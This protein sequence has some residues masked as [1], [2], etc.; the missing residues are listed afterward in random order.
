M[1]RGNVLLITLDQLS[2]SA[3][4]G[5]LA[6]YVPTPN[7]DRLGAEGT[8]F[9]NHFTVTVP[10][11]PARASLLTGLY[12]MNH[13]A[14]RNGTPL[15]RH[16][17][18]LATEARKAG[19]EPLL[20]GYTDFAADPT[21][22][23]PE[24]P[25][26][27]IY[28]GVAPGFREMVEMRL[29]GGLEWP[30]YLRAKGYVFDYDPGA[31]AFGQFRPQCDPNAASKPSDPAIYRA[32]DSDTAYLTDRTLDALDIRKTAPWFAHLTYLRPH[33]PLVAPAPYN[34]LVD[35]A[36]L[37]LP[38]T[39]APDHPFVEAWFSEASKAGMFWGFAGDCRG[40]DA[41]T[42]QACRAV[43]LGL[44]AEVDHHLG[45][46]L[47]WLEETGQADKTLVVLTADH[48]EMLGEKAMWGK[49][50]VFE[51]AYHVPMML[52]GPGIPVGEVTAL[53]ASVDVMPT[54][55]DWIGQEV[56]DAVDG[57]SL[58]PL[59][60]GEVSGARDAVLMEA[61]FGQPGAPTRFERVMGLEPLQTSVSILREARWK[62]IHFGGG[63]PPMLFDLEAD[64]FETRDVAPDHPDQV[65]RMARKMIDQMSERRDRRL[66]QISQGV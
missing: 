56:P 43:Y 47:D 18:T 59:A 49:D 25:D 45:R 44:L 22:R 12:A 53:T 57:R 15:A 27:S 10:C 40:M 51:P 54:V 46:V 21:G 19:Y 26:L 14:I 41:E 61:D 38:E 2:A 20:F 37:P 63:V 23:D 62:Y 35:P 65:S 30:G 36:T 52:R 48:G 7:I 31:G 4:F 50:S 8:R 5:P 55:L 24:D 17:A 28:E 66:T 13:R 34:R 64:P 6:P 42:V 60:Q 39:T 33:P 32:E 3:I 1:T 58:L 29:D 11:G 9:L 16:H